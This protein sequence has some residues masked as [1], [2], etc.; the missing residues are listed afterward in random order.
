MS[1][2]DLRNFTE[3]MRG[4]GYPRLISVE[5]FR[6][7]NFELVAEILLWLIQRYEPDAHIPKDID[8]EQDRVIFIKSSAQF[9][10]TKIHIK[11]NTKRLY[12]A[13]GYSVK[14]LLKVASVLHS[15]MKAIDHSSAGDSQSSHSLTTFDIASKINELKA[16]RQLASEVTQRGA[17][18]YHLLSQEP[19]LRD[20]RMSA[21]AHPLDINTIEKGLRSSIMKVEQN[22]KST[23]QKLDNV[24][25][26]EANL[27]AKIEKR[28]SELDRSKKRLSTLQSVR[29]AFMDEFERL[30]EELKLQYASYLI[31]FRNMTYLEHQMEDHNRQEQARMNEN[32][33]S[34]RRIQTRLREEEKKVILND[35]F[36]DNDALDGLGLGGSG[37]DSD[38]L[39]NENLEKRPQ[40]PERPHAGVRR[41]MYI[42]GS[43]DDSLSSDDIDVADDDDDDDVISDDEL[44]LRGEVPEGG[45]PSQD[46]DDDDD[47]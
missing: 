43:D 2:R 47:F 1:Y 26:D 11:L 39:N 5:N 4:L 6:Q 12:M 15:A 38:D 42:D 41:S 25:A 23:L 21:L 3:M 8:T 45:V 40:N 46:E 17:T 44:M 27:E 37:E 32:E 24:A 33:L 31:K 14:E 16:V 28:K 30:E 36:L 35:S 9:I 19:E 29:P 18:L 20:A 13:D 34:L 10:A 22:T 7:P